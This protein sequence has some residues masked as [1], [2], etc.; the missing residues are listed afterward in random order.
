MQYFIISYLHF[1][2]AA[3]KN[4]QT[5]RTSFFDKFMKNPLRCFVPFLQQKNQIF[6]TIYVIFVIF[7]KS[8]LYLIQLTFLSIRRPMMIENGTVKF[9]RFHTF[10]PICVPQFQRAVG[11][12]RREHA[13][14]LGV[15]VVKQGG[16]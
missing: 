5:Y 7:L 12:S 3:G 11:A 14:V 4:H 1:E 2:I 6:Q 9:E 8:S 13:R 10:H 15:P 16:N